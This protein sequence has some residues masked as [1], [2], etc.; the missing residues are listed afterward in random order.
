MLDRLSSGLV[1]ACRAI[2]FEAPLSIQAMPARRSRKQEAESRLVRE[3]T[4]QAIDLL[5]G[6]IESLKRERHPS[7]VPSR[8]LWRSG[9]LEIETEM[10]VVRVDGKTIRVPRKEFLILRLLVEAH[11]APVPRKALWSRSAEDTP[12]SSRSLDAHIWSLRRKIEKDP[13][14]PK[15][16]IT[17]FRHGYRLE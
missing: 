7:I 2:N 10:W 17:V 11:G 16:L 9:D 3:G 14:N 13:A 8:N 6:V 1:I 4:E 12:Q 5:S 15:H